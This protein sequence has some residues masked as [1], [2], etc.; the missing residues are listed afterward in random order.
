MPQSNYLIA[1]SNLSDLTNPILARKNLGR[2]PGATGNGVVDDTTAITT[3][4]A[5][6][7]AANTPLVLTGGWTYTVGTIT[8]PSNLHVIGDGLTTIKLKN[9]AGG[10]LFKWAAST[11]NNVVFYNLILNGNRTNQPGDPINLTSS[12]F[13]GL[14]GAIVTNSKFISLNIFNF[15]TSGFGWEYPFSLI[16]QDTIFDDIKIVNIG[17]TGMAGN[18]LRCGVTRSLVDNSADGLSRNNDYGFSFSATQST[19]RT[20]RVLMNATDLGSANRVGFALAGSVTV[21]GGSAS[22]NTLDDIDIDCRSGPLNFSYTIDGGFDN[23]DG[24]SD[25]KLTNLYSRNCV[26]NCDYEILNQRNLQ[27]SNWSVINGGGPSGTSVGLI[28]KDTV[29]MVLNGFYYDSTNQIQDAIRLGAGDWPATAQPSKDITINGYAIDGGYSIARIDACNN[30]TFSNG[31]AKDIGGPGF[32]TYPGGS[33]NILTNLQ[34]LGLTLDG[35]QKPW[36]ID[37]VSG[38][39]LSNIIC[40]NLSQPGFEHGAG[41]SNVMLHGVKGV[42]FETFSNTQSFNGFYEG[43]L[44]GYWMFGQQGG[45][46]GVIDLGDTLP[47]NAVV[48]KMDGFIMASVTSAGGT[49]KISIGL[50]GNTGAF[51]PASS[52]WVI[53]NPFQ[54]IQDGALANNYWNFA[55]PANVAVE[56]SVEPLTAGFL[57]WVIQYYVRPS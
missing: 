46:V 32:Y 8:V 23:L 47:K 56:I 11:T 15:S 52:G 20:L 14:A 42:A 35:A 41:C 27:S 51:V 6:C 5:G 24:A 31:I 3:A 19:F 45:A 49:G 57:Q 22:G 28:I 37:H 21:A 10:P 36:D 17:Q 13:Y 25:N 33:S 26:N 53:G 43:K 38:A 29:G 40:S 7:V 18:L 12:A 39:N 16:Y 9:N 44:N 30:I 50:V 55:A 54:G 1:T 48:T 2:I 34:V 4:I